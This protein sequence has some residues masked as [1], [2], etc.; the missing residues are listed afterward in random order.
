MSLKKATIFI[1]FTI[2]ITGIPRTTTTN[3]ISNAAGVN[4]TGVSLAA[5]DS[6]KDSPYTAT[7]TFESEVTAREFMARKKPHSCL[8][9]HPHFDTSFLG[10]TVLK[11]SP[12]DGIE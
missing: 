4:P 7:V 8:G 5:T 2:R 1:M 11:S 9:S 12:N 10:L 3:D 6:A